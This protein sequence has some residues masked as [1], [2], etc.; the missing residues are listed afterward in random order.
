MIELGRGGEAMHSMRDWDLDP[1]NPR[2]FIVRSH[3]YR[4]QRKYELALREVN[5]AIELAV[6]S[7]SDA[8]ARDISFTE[9]AKV[10]EAMGWTNLAIQDLEQAIECSAQGTFGR[11]RLSE[12]LAKLRSLSTTAEGG[13]QESSGGKGS[14]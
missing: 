11:R 7:S 14:E 1:S 4:K 8:S 2:I 3:Y 12:R 13:A 9:R 10:Y 6:P 5:Q